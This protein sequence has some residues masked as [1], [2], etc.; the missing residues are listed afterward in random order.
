MYNLLC[1]LLYFT[2]GNVTTGGEN[3]GFNREKGLSAI[4]VN[5]FPQE[6]RDTYL[7]TVL[8]RH[9]KVEV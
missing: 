2:V 4:M 1:S 9:V 8:E 3:T 6:L 7:T 5:P